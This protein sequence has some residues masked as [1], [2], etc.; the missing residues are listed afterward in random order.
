MTTP[1]DDPDVPIEH[2]EYLYQKTGGGADGRSGTEYEVFV[3]AFELIKLAK[4]VLR[5]NLDATGVHIT[6]QAIGMYIDDVVIRIGDEFQHFEMKTGGNEIWGKAPKTIRWNFEEQ[7]LFNERHSRPSTY[8]LVLANPDVFDTLDGSRAEW[9]N[10]RFFPNTSKPTEIDPHVR[11]FI[12][13]ITDLLPFEKQEF[14]LKKLSGRRRIYLEFDHN[15]VATAYEGFQRAFQ[16]L[17]SGHEETVD[18]VLADAARHTHGLVRY[19]QQGFDEGVQEKLDEIAGIKFVAFKGVVF[20]T[21]MGNFF[22]R[23]PIE[24][25][26]L[27]G[28]VFQDLVKHNYFTNAQQLRAHMEELA[29]EEDWDGYDDED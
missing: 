16:D 1:L 15:D 2:K 14:L 20:F 21:I 7:K 25:G 5:E 8:G 11:G 24:L 19:Q 29:V 9:V 12:E 10:V 23:A 13:A 26:G 27:S 28:K 3:A 18:R 17:E 4:A 22:G 6:W